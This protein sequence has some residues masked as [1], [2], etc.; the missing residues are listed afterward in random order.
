MFWRP[1]AVIDYGQNQ[2]G[3]NLARCRIRVTGPEE[4]GYLPQ[5]VKVK[6]R[7][8]F[9]GLIFCP[10]GTDPSENDFAFLL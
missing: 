6:V 7:Q 2:I 9:E 5:V 10:E 3:S 1:R 4:L 8:D